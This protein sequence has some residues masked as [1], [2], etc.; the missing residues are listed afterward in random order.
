MQYTEKEIK[1]ILEAHRKWLWSEE[2][3][4]RAVLTG[5]DLRRAVLTGAVLTGADLRRADF[6]ELGRSITPD[7][8]LRKKVASYIL[9]H[10]GLLVMSHWH[11]DTATWRDWRKENPDA[12]PNGE[13]C[14]T[15]HCEAG[16][17]V[18]FGSKD[19]PRILEVEDQFGTPLAAHLLCPEIPIADFYIDNEEKLE[20]MRELVGVNLNSA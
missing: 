7:P 3:G 14:D 20:Q 17:I 8:T 1:R 11:Q 4:E 6:G 9:S 5:A 15:T 19:Q 10:Q 18:V 13:Y 16:W 2:G 12:I